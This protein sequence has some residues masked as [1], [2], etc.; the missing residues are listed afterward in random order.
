MPEETT[1]TSV[2]LERHSAYLSITDD[3]DGPFTISGI[4]IGE[5]DV[6]LG[7]SGV[8]KKWTR[9]A[10]KAG[11]DSLKERPLVVDHENSAYGVVGEV[12]RVE[13][14]DGV[15]VLYEAELDDEELA[16][17]IEN[18]RLEV[19]IRGF[20]ED[21]EE[22]QE[23]AETG[24]KL[25]TKLKFANLSIVPKGAAPSNT[26][27]IG[28]ST[29]ISAAEC[30]EM[31]GLVDEEENAER[32]EGAEEHGNPDAVAEQ[33]ERFPEGEETPSDKRGVNSTEEA[34][35]EEDTPSHD[36]VES[37]LDSQ[38]RGAGAGENPESILAKTNFIKGNIMTDEI[39]AT[40]EEYNA[41]TVIEGGELDELKEQ[42]SKVSD[43]EEQLTE[44]ADEQDAEEQTAAEEL[45]EQFSSDLEELKERN[46]VLDTVN[47]EDVES[48]AD[49]DAPLVVETDDYEEL[50]AEVDEVKTVYAEDLSEH[51]ALDADTIED[52]FSISE[53]KEQLETFEAESEETEEE[54][55]PDLDATD[56][57]EDELEEAAAEA[58]G[59][60]EDE[61]SEEAAA[62]QERLSAMI[63]G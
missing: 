61:L 22:M 2:E 12:T 26:V 58:H 45:K 11:T 19:S 15:G 36:E 13:Y 8:K 59:E 56:V 17:K 16:E 52:K 23:D 44:L 37:E 20:H 27:E 24:A 51:I 3:E 10:L 1:E 32:P 53:M 14:R 42:A 54:L 57:D 6:T 49:A 5:E 43:L 30:A 35:S 9:T 62:E 21:V 28:A 33:P 48:L 4:A 41:P 25:V 55:S 40:L 60:T 31:L 34:G 39:E 47:R 46:A 63:Q 50:Q 7:Q 29:E 38:S 18:G